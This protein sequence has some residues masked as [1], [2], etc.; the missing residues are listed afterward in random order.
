VGARANAPARKPGDAE[1]CNL[2]VSPPFGF[3]SPRRVPG[4]TVAACEDPAQGCAII[5]EDDSSVRPRLIRVAGGRPGRNHIPD[6]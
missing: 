4:V 5:V 3:H 1:D 6:T 2:A